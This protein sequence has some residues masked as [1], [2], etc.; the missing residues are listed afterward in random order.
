MRLAT[1]SNARLGWLGL[2]A[3]SARQGNEDRLQRGAEI[4][5][6]LV[7]LKLIEKSIDDF[8][9]MDN[10]LGDIDPET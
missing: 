10:A 6:R 1:I 9:V 2:I 8:D 3:R 5:C 4:G 7:A